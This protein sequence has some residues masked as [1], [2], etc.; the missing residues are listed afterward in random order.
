M[1]SGGES[2]GDSS[3]IESPGP[4]HSS[5]PAS[6]A[7]ASSAGPTP[8]AANSSKTAPMEPQNLTSPRSAKQ[9]QQQHSSKPLPL[10]KAKPSTATNASHHP[11]NV[12]HQQQQ[13]Q[14]QQLQHVQRSNHA[15]G[16]N[17]DDSGG[18]ATVAYTAAD[19]AKVPPDVLLSL[20]Q[21]GHLQVH[22]EE[23]ESD[24]HDFLGV[25]HD[26]C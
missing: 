19:L 7:V 9:Q 14:P 11:M 2:D 3:G 16:N 18:G 24:W 25:K 15:T 6:L 10:V 21:A 17:T 23:G 20:V 22:Q 4:M 13:Q 8:A 26:A 1:S 5:Q 12:P